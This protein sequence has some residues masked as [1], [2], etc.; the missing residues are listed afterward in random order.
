[1]GKL[2]GSAVAEGDVRQL[3]GE[4]QSQAGF[5]GENVNEPAADDDGVPDGK[6]FD[7]SGE[8][9]A[10]VRVDVEVGGNDQVAD[11]RV[12]KLIDRSWRS[13]QAAL[14]Q[15]RQNVF[16]RLVL[17]GPLAFERREILYIGLVVH[18]GIAFNENFRQLVKLIRRSGSIIPDARLGLE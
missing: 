2:R 6:C 10:A 9:D 12:Q 17:P 16:L 14:F 5:I 7:G 11:H 15:A 13:E 3:V 18:R 1:E 4:D 8:Q